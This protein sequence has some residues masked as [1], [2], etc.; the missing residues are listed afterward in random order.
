MY[1]SYNIDKIHQLLNGSKKWIVSCK[2]EQREY[3]YIYFCSIWHIYK[4]LLLLKWEISHQQVEYYS[5]K[6]K[7]SLINITSIT[8]IYE[9]TILHWWIIFYVEATP[10]PVSTH[11]YLC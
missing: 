2:K 10:Q 7:L 8:I 11:R 4:K 6:N 3:I 5:Y 9:T 1:L